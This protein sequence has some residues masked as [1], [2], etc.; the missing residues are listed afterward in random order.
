VPYAA[1]LAVSALCLGFLALSLNAWTLHPDH[2]PDR[3]APQMAWYQ[4]EL[5]YTQVGQELA[6]RVTPQTLIAAG[7]V[8]ALGY[9]SNARILD[10]VGLMS[11]E[12]S[13]Y[14]PL[15]PALYVISYAVPPQLIL[16]YQ[17]DYVV[18][19]EIYGRKGLFADPRFSAE[20]ELS[21]KIPSDVFGSD[22]MLV[23]TRRASLGAMA[24]RV[25][26][27]AQP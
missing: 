13:R 20:Y 14:Y 27:A 21:Q 4:M 2:G 7:D 15:D 24:S 11:P 19:M 6:P 25:E 5:L 17:P 23:W 12:A 22:G 8:G 3:P 16:D 26:E 1:P 18:L 9:Y 10:T